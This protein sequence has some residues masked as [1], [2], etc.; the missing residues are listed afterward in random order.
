LYK[1]PLAEWLRFIGEN[2]NE[3]CGNYLTR[4]HEDMSCLFE[5]RGKL[6]L[7]RVMNVVG[8]EYQT[9]KIPLL[10]LKLGRKGKGLLRVLEKL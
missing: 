3:I 10:T 5:N 8:F 4:E 6:Q 9:M 7:N 2:C 1:A